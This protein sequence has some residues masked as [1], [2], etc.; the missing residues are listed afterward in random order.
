MGSTIDVLITGSSSSISNDAVTVW[1]KNASGA[2]SHYFGKFPISYVKISVRLAGSGRINDGVTD[3]DGIRIRLG[4]RTK[5]EDLNRDW[6]LVHEMCHL[7]FPDLDD[8]YL[9]LREGL[10]SYLEPLARARV[11]MLREADVWKD[12]VEGMPQ[13]EPEAG[14]HGLDVT[15]TWGRTYWGGAMFCLLLDLQIREQTHNQKSIDDAMRAILNQ[16]GDRFSHWTID[17]VIAAADK[18]TGTSA[19]RELYDQM[20]HAQVQVDLQTVWKKLGINYHFGTITF[21]DSAP[22]AAIRRSMTAEQSR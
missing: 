15:H 13:G 6:V 12:V 5:Q 8:Q 21:D 19:M 17:H 16:G 4:K 3:N 20:S 14:D 7:A 11:G 10:A 22:L 2:V 9:W 18:A 1:V